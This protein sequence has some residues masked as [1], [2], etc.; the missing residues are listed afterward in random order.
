MQRSSGTW[1]KPWVNT[2][3]STG[4]TL[5]SVRKSSRWKCMASY[6]TVVFRD[7]QGSYRSL[8]CLKVFEIHHCFFKALRSL[9]NSTFLVRVLKSLSISFFANHIIAIL[10]SW[11]KILVEQFYC[12]CKI[13][14]HIIFAAFPVV[15]GCVKITINNNRMVLENIDL[16]VESPWKVLDFWL[17]FCINPLPRMC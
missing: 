14:Q 8:K 3:C 13:S 9:Q 15:R 1:W 2:W 11:V 5:V 10:Q 4:R 16:V 17:V 7:T 12:V 6:Q